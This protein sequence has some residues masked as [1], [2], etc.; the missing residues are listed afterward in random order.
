MV[1]YMQNAHHAWDNEKQWWT[2]A[3]PTIISQ[4]QKGKL[5]LLRREKESFLPQ[6]WQWH[7]MPSILFGSWPCPRGS[8]PHP[9]TATAK[10]K[11]D[12]WQGQSNK[13]KFLWVLSYN[14]SSPMQCY[15]KFISRV[16]LAHQ[17]Q[18]K[19]FSV[20]VSQQRWKRGRKE[21]QCDSL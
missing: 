16:A 2:H 9:L 12:S 13:K 10:M 6:S 5:F 1:I 19:H 21:R 7:K 17:W 11:Q 15:L 20:W 8:W 18:K 3:L 14:C 4:G